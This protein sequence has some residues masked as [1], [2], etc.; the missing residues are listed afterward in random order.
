MWTVEVND[1]FAANLDGVTTLMSRYITSTER[2]FTLKKAVQLFCHDS[3]VQ[4]SEHD[5][6]VCYG[7]SKMTVLNEESSNVK[8]YHILEPVEMM[9]LIGRV[10][11]CKYKETSGLPLQ[12]KIE[13]LLDI[14]FEVIGFDRKELGGQ[15]EQES[16]SDCEY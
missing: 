1:V 12:T 16:C 11:E 7:L 5:L 14:L 2:Q 8:K 3:A 13:F 9:E 6:G 4:I 15:I 10:A